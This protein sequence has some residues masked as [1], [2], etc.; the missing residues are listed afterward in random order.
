MR[1]QINTFLAFVGIL[2]A[3]TLQAPPA[4]AQ[5]QVTT[6]VVA[7]CGTATYVAGKMAYPTQDTTGKACTDA[8]GG[9][10]GG[11]VTIADGAD[12]TQGALADAACA[13]D[14]GTCSIAALLKRNN[15]R[16]TSAI[17][18]TTVT[19]SVTANLGTLGGAATAAL[20]GAQ[21]TGSTYNPPT[22]GSGEIGYLSGIY[23]AAI[24]PTAVAITCSLCSTAA[25]QTSVIGTAAAG[26]AATNSLLTGMVYNSGGLSLTNGQQ[27]ALQSESTGQL[28]VSI[29]ANGSSAQIQ[30]PQDNNPFNSGNILVWSTPALNSAAGNV[31]QVGRTVPFAA[32]TVGTGV[33]ATGLALWSTTDLT[34]K[35]IDTASSG[36]YQLA[37]AGGGSNTHRGH[38]LRLTAAGTVKVKITDGVGGAVL[39]QFEMIAGSVVVLELSDRPYF[40]G[41]ANTVLNMNLSAAVQVSG[42]LEFITA[43]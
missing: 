23:A 4:Y 43:T 12:V 1:K 2:F 16:I 3:Y 5:T 34:R 19:G 24:D 41:T 38:R 37:A 27:G 15:Q 6:K 13:T 14:N 42:I 7:T 35:L 40:K 8:T 31:K 36:D 39:E 33:Q 9:G 17:A 29:Y 30:T 32:N 10:G 20:Q 28:K 26:T 25:N 21:G 22:G 18:G 11:A